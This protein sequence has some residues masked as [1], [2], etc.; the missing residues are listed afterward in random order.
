MPVASVSRLCQLI[1][2]PARSRAEDVQQILPTDVAEVVRRIHGAQRA[3][4]DVPLER[5]AAESC[6]DLAHVDAPHEVSEDAQAGDAALLD[7]EADVDFA[8]W[9]AARALD[10]AR[11][12]YAYPIYEDAKRALDRLHAE[13]RIGGADGGRRDR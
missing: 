13:L 1:Q 12:A 3:G 5:Q 2:L 6:L 11:A 7:V 4:R 9:E 10:V 8:H